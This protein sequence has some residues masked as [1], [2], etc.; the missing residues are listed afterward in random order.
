[1]YHSIESCIVCNLFIEEYDTVPNVFAG[2]NDLS[3][4]YAT[5]EVLSLQLLK[6]SLFQIKTPAL[7]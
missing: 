3:V 6:R 4:P 1:M 5:S 2:T 7:Y